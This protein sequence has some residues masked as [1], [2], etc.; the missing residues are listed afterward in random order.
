VRD[1]SAIDLDTQWYCDQ[2]L[3]AADEI[4][5]PF[6]V[7]KDTLEDWFNERGVYWLPEDF[8]RQQEYS[9]RYAMFPCA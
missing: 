1:E 3:R 8:V 6:G 9:P 7:P 4:L 2:L 5:S